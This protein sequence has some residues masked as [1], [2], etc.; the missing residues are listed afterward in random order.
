MVVQKR[1]NTRYYSLGVGRSVDNPPPGTVV[2]SHI[3]RRHLY[4][5]FLVSQKVTQGTVSPTHYVVVEGCEVMPPDVMQALSYKLT[6]MYYNWPGTIRV[7]SP[8]QVGRGGRGCD[9]YTPVRSTSDWRDSLGNQE[10][11]PSNAKYQ[12]S[13]CFLS[14]WN[15][16]SS[17]QLISNELFLMLHMRL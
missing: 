6:H 8:C 15:S 16:N 2:D 11:N 4:D 12:N 3:T 17:H 13:D 10:N 7:P 9:N 5:Y 14:H 1:I